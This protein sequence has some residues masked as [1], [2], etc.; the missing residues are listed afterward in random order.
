MQV[1]IINSTNFKV[2]TSSVRNT[3]DP[4]FNEELTIIDLFPSLSQRIKIEICYADRLRKQVHSSRNISLKSIS[5][6]KEDGF[7]PTFGP[8][9]LHLYTKNGYEDHAGTILI[10][11]KTEVDELGLLDNRKS[12]LVKAIPPL[13]EVLYK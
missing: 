13:D 4:V 2:K 6:D 12:S 9:F 8:I 3:S 11:M 1:K 5:S 10:E 7:L